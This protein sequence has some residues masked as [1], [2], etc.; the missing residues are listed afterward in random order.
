MNDFFSLPLS[1]SSIGKY[2]E[3]TELFNLP[4]S[5]LPFQGRGGYHE[6]ELC[7]YE[8]ELSK[9]EVELYEC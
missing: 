8:V 3:D 2:L 9:H 4:L 6:V 5:R 1:S 7:K